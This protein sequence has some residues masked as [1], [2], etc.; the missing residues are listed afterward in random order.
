[1]DAGVGGSAG[2]SG[3]SGGTAGSGG[4]PSGGQGGTSLGGS[5]G[6][7]GSAGSAGSG[8]GAGAGGSGGSA[9]CG[10]TQTFCSGTCVD[11]YA[12]LAN[13]GACQTA[14][15]GPYEV[16]SGGCVQPIDEELILASE[17][18]IVADDAHVAWWLEGTSSYT[19]RGGN[20]GAAWSDLATIQT[21]QPINLITSAGIALTSTSVL[22]GFNEQLHTRIFEI[23]FASGIPQL[24]G[25]SPNA[26][27][28]TAH[29]SIAK[30]ATHLFW[31]GA[32]GIFRSKN[33]GSPEH[34]YDGYIAQS[35]V[36]DGTELWWQLANKSNSAIVHASIDAPALGFVPVT[37]V[38]A[39]GAKY[40]SA[41]AIRG[42]LV[43]LLRTDG[44]YRKSRS[45]GLEE[46]VADTGANSDIESLVLDQTNV[47][48][49][50][51]LVPGQT[52]FPLF[53]THQ[54]QPFP[55]YEATS[56]ADQ[57]FW[58]AAGGGFLYWTTATGHLYRA[59]SP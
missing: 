37:F 42:D 53:Y 1:V 20:H 35:V 41:F 44:V 36:I 19:I 3:G 6:V 43:Y 56:H 7:G 11:T 12:N 55:K 33:G 34:F 45:S 50:Q 39:V 40:F 23:P 4:T 54:T 29:V 57:T 32:K 46:K 24:L 5:A 25:E 27:A 8:G 59:P 9:G 2:G 47:Y 16:C 51:L 52:T 14:C 31:S 22:F 17:N 15:T 10:A 30:T 49:T 18:G 26:N 21:D 13:C 28:S 58:V 48:F 38:D